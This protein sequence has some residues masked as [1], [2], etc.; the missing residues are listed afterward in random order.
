MDLRFGTLT[1]PSFLATA[2]VSPRLQ[3]IR[4]WFSFGVTRPQ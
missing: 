2:I 3:V 1:Q 4:S